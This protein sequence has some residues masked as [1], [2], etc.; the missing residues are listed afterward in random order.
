[1]AKKVSFNSRKKMYIV[2]EEGKRGIQYQGKKVPEFDNGEDVVW[3]C[4]KP[5][6]IINPKTGKK[7]RVLDEIEAVEVP[8]AEN[9][10]VDSVLNGK[11]VVAGGAEYAKD[12]I[13]K[14]GIFKG[15]FRS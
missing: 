15:L 1:M 14:A 10:N 5:V 12:Q 11:A 8:T 7:S 13:A 2:T 9:D 3:L 6:D 4:D